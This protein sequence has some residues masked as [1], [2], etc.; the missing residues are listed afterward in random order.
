MS[1]TID[2]K[3]KEIKRL[4]LEEMIDAIKK[5]GVNHGN[6]TTITFGSGSGFNYGLLPCVAANH[7]D[8]PE[9]VLVKDIAIYPG[10]YADTNIV[11]LHCSTKLEEEDV[12]IFPNDL[13]AGELSV[14]VDCII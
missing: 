7:G 14:I 10:K 2:E 6:K 3:V 1:T 9:D 13:Y 5:H 12:T 11:A 8:N 4:E